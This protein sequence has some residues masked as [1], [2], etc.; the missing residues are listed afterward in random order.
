M[1]WN[2]GACVPACPPDAIYEDEDECIDKAEGDM[3]KVLIKNYELYLDMS[4][5]MDT[6]WS[7]CEQHAL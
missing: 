2:C 7:T 1:Y 3:M 5:R 6:K 4:F